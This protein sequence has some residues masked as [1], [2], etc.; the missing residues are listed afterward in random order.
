MSPCVRQTEIRPPADRIAHI[1]TIDLTREELAAGE[2]LSADE[3]VRAGRMRAPYQSRW[4]ASREGLRRILARYAEAN[5]R[6]LV[7]G[8]KANGKPLTE[9]GPAFSMS[10]T[11]D[12]ALV[13]VT[14][15]GEIGVDV[16]E[17]RPFDDMADLLDRFF[18]PVER[19]GINSTEPERRTDAF[20]RCWTRKEAAVK[21]EGS[22]LRALEGLSVDWSDVERPAVLSTPKGFADPSLWTLISLAPSPRHVGAL[23]TTGS[24]EQ[25][26]LFQL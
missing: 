15:R 14:N 20:Y 5:P 8:T 23:A 21:A 2:S 6:S 22:G 26:E 13:A 19:R 9:Q 10:H 4:I 1:W 16:E 12:V 25:I 18:S 7:I 17:V 3:R 11:R 24:I